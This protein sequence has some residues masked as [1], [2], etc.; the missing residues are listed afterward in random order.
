MGGNALSTRSQDRPSEATV[1]WDLGVT[2]GTP[3]TERF[4]ENLRELRAS[5]AVI[6]RLPW[7]RLGHFNTAA[8]VGNAPQT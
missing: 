5:L 3:P 2:P 4:S 6:L 1:V 8:V 7:G